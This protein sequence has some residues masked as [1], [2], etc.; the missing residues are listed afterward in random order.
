MGAAVSSARSSRPLRPWVIGPRPRSS[1]ARSRGPERHNPARVT[2]FRRDVSRDDRSFWVA[3]LA[4]REDAQ[5][6]RQ[7]AEA[8][9]QEEAQKAP[10]TLR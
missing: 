6:K 1:R 10:L 8:L 3:V 9:A 4:A 2:T 5:A 7:K